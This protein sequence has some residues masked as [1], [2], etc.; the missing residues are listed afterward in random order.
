M[1]EA[2]YYLRDSSLVQWRYQPYMEMRFWLMQPD[3]F[4]KEVEKILIYLPNAAQW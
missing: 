1:Q 2:S 4:I 3:N